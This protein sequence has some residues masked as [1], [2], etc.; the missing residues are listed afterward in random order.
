MLDIKF[1]RENAEAVKKNCLHRGI[2]CDI[3]ALLA[4]DQKR[5]ELV[6]H[7]EVLKALK[8][9][10]N[11]LILEAKTDEEKK[12]VI[13]KGKE[14]KANLEKS[15]PEL[16]KV[17]E[18]YKSI[19]N[20]VPNMHSED[21][22][23]G[24]DE[25]EN[26]VIK[27]LGEPKKFEF[28][29]KEHWEIGESLDVI[30]IKRATKV[31]GSRFSYLKGELALLEQ[32]LVQFAFSVL[33]D[34]SVLKEIVEK[35]NLNVSLRKFIPIIPPVLIKREALEK[36]ARLEPKEERYY[37][38]SDDLYLVGS[39]EHSIGAMHM[40]EILN[41]KELPL[42]YVGFSP[43]FRRE[44]GS[45]GK[46]TKGILRVHQFDKLE[47]VSFTS[48]DSGLDEQN[49]I[50]AIQE[51]LMI[52]LG[53]PYQIVAICTGDMGSPDFR[54][55]D[56]E[57]WLP[58]QNRYRETHS[59][60]YNTDYQSRRLN[61]KVKKGDGKSE[62][63]HM[64]DA[65]AFAIGRTIIAI[66]ENYQQADGSVKIPEILIKYMPGGISEIRSK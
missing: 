23:I 17:F 26:K 33:T 3:D 25:S 42:R 46:D 54:Q 18:E 14:I 36:M 60:D 20:K 37:I 1:I 4:L 22:P 45:Y 12:E 6:K 52:S 15:E 8:N 38:P 44:A 10:L 62:L 13:E 39:A 48:P 11:D 28:K 63:V 21:T 41:I 32:A 29:A 51:Y 24:K 58:G 5:L 55:I 64:N 49:F 61:I 7:V 65:T 27:K 66:M 53:L 19:L 50:V 2:Q 43:A 56:V 34:E 47:I 35:N 16:D 30:D 57:T 9:D 31:S 59:S 40:D